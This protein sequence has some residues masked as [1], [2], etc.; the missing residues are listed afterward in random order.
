MALQRIDDNFDKMVSSVLKNLDPAFPIKNKKELY[1]ISVINFL[2]EWDK[3][4]KQK[5]P[6]FQ[7]RF[8]E[9]Y[10]EKIKAIKKILI[11]NNWM[12]QTDRRKK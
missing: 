4:I 8:L 2:Q 5:E 7:K 6:L 1:E 9:K 11:K 10:S 3:I 12:P